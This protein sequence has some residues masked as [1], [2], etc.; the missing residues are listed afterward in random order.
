MIDKLPQAPKKLFLNNQLNELSFSNF[1]EGGS[2]L[3][4][5]CEDDRDSIRNPSKLGL[6]GFDSSWG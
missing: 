5:F 1:F 6:K 3:V 4:L 2:S